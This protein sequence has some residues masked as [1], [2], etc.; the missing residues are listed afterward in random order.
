MGCATAHTVFVWGALQQCWSI[1]VTLC[2]FFWFRSDFSSFLVT[3]CYFLW[4]WSIVDILCHFLWFWP[5]WVILGHFWSPFLI[6]C[7]FRTFL[8]ILV[9]CLHFRLFL[10][11][12]KNEDRGGGKENYLEKSVFVFSLHV[13]SLQYWHTPLEWVNQTS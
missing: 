4:F 9:N 11:K 1:M 8:V 6:F 3:F 2:H 5:I 13:F 12:I 10:S 7:D